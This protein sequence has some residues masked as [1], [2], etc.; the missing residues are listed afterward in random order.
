MQ[1]LPLKQYAALLCETI[2]EY[3]FPPVTYDFV[4]DPD[5]KDKDNQDNQNPHKKNNLQ[6][7][8]CMR[9]AEKYI[10]GLLHSKKPEAVKNGL[11]NVLYWGYAQ[12]PGRRKDR[13]SKFRTTNP[14][15]LDR[16]IELVEES[17]RSSTN[18]KVPSGG[19]CL[20]QIKN[21]KLPE[22]SQMP[23]VSKILMFLDPARYPVLDTKIAKAYANSFSSPLQKLKFNPAKDTSIRITK[24]NAAVYDTWACW[25]H[26]IASVVNDSPESP[27][28]HFRAVDVERALFTL[29]SLNKGIIYNSERPA[30]NPKSSPQF[31]LHYTTLASS[32][33]G[34]FL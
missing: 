20:L 34:F 27:C 6:S 2:R 26:E 24:D 9:A 10:G 3:N 32:Y 7:N 13:I 12:Q 25:C 33:L 11:L 30:L 29:A 15:E 14:N 19:S 1:K 21:L 23:F 4:K 22:F 28:N 17:E 18:G 16:F 31:F 5:Y 8:D